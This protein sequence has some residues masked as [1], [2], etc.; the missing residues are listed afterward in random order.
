[1]SHPEDAGSP[2]ERGEDRPRP[3]RPEPVSQSHGQPVGAAGGYG[4]DLTGAAKIVDALKAS[5][6]QEFYIA[7]RLSAKA[8]QAFALAAGFF[9]VGQ[10]VAFGNFEAMKLSAHEKHWVIGLAIGAIAALAFAVVL[11]LKSD[12]TYKSRDLPLESLEDDLN[13]AYKGDPDVMG[14]LGSYYLGIVRTRRQANNSRRFW[15]R[16]TLSAVIVSLTVTVCELIF[17]LLSRTT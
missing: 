9:I 14:N 12:A 1:M 11:A 6:D 17:S 5:A 15:Y 8:R 7:E 4:P 10:T 2:P 16:L 13:A 3:L